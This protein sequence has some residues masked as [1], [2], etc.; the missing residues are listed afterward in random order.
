MR[1][2][3][4]LSG[5]AALLGAMTPA[6]RAKGRYMRGPDHPFP[7]IQSKSATEIGNELRDWFTSKF[8]GSETKAAEL[9][10]RIE[11]L[12]QRA[13]RPRGS[14]GGFVDT[15]GAQVAASSELKAL[16]D[17]RYRPGLGARIEL[18]AITTV[19]GSG[20]GLIYRDQDRE[21]ASAPRRL[22]RVR[23]LLTVIPTTSGSID[24]AQQTLRTNNARPVA[25]GTQKPYSEYGWTKVNTPVRTIAHLSKLTRQAADDAAQ[26][27][28]EVDTEMRYGLQ[29]AE[30]V[31]ILSGDGTG[32]NLTG[33]LTVATAF[34]VPAGM[35]ITNPTRIDRIG[36]AIAQ[37][38]LAEFVPDGI[39]LN[40]L[41]WW[42]IKLLKDAA[43]GYISLDPINGKVG[44]SEAP[45]LFGLPV[46]VTTAMP[47]GSFSVGAYRRQKL[48][49][50]LAPEVLISSENA[51]DFEKNLL[52]M[53]CEERVA[54]ANRYPAAIIKGTFG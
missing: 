6:E 42:M 40:P 8:T 17:G 49:D 5:G 35:A 7:A 14:G 31:Q 46:A 10:A 15:Y 9:M 21:I 37:L 38:A 41:D 29:L 20:G 3:T 32:E 53:R 11:E 27:Q 33:M 43:G 2:L 48:Y 18:K 51:D 19:G 26:L 36:Q 50:R 13:D 30:D 54:L 25:E 22:I 47:A 28:G 12:E 39:I 34:A 24:Y 52:T 16:Q 45:T 1:K 44:E 23:D 4:M